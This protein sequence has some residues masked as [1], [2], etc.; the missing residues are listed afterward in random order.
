MDG[1]QPGFW[2]VE[3][4]GALGIE[5]MVFL[6]G[7]RLT[8]ETEGR[9][10]GGLPYRLFAGQGRLPQRYIAGAE[11]RTLWRSQY[12]FPLFYFILEIRLSWSLLLL[13]QQMS[14]LRFKELVLKLLDLAGEGAV[15]LLQGL[16]LC[17]LALIFQ[18]HLSYLLLQA[19]HPC[20]GKRGWSTSRSCSLGLAGLDLFYV[21][22]QLLHNPHHELLILTQRSN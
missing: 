8:H 7:L 21:L 20:I 18:A 15:E 14:M 19:R 6:T 3:D 1:A 12:S 10:S 11:R 4:R 13:I 2:L 22:G 17:L 9:E 16:H 5:D